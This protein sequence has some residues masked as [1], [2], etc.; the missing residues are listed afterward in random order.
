MKVIIANWKSQ[1]SAAEAEA[2][3]TTFARQV[4]SIDPKLQIVIAPPMPLVG[5]VAGW[6]KSLKLSQIQLGVQDLSPFPPG[7][8]TG[9]TSTQ[10][11]EGF[12]VKWAIFGHSE[13]RRYFHETHQQIANKVEQALQA[14]MS[15]VVCVDEADIVSQMVAIDE[16]LHSRCYVAYEPVAAI[17]SGQ[18]EPVDHVVQVGNAIT[19]QFKPRTIMYGGSVSAGSIKEYLQVTDG[20]IVATHSQDVSDFIS[21]IHAAI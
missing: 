10:N 18:Q 17:G 14:S 6:L 5:L 9:A 21:V 11:L 12:D 1:K 8:Y 16:K 20:V 2:W 19:S 13:R 4:T 15:P 7:S 3:L